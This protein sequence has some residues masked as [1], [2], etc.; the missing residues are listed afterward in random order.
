MGNCIA[1]P[2]GDAQAAVAPVVAP[3]A[4]KIVGA[5][6]NKVTPLPAATITL[7][8]GNHAQHTLPSAP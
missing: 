6:T 3:D 4:A 2:G 8:T 5:K 7:R 1:K